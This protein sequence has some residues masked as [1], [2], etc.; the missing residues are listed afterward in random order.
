ME[1]AIEK[2]KVVKP[3]KK[4]KLFARDRIKPRGA[5]GWMEGKIH[6]DENADVFNLSL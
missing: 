1:K 2:R 3:A 6:Y 4:E 5:W